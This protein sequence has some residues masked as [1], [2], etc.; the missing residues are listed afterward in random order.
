MERAHLSR[1]DMGH[2]GEVDCWCEPTPRVYKYPDHRKIMVVIHYD[3]D[4]AM[5]RE[6]I[7]NLRE[8]HRDS[9]TKLLDQVDTVV[10]PPTFFGLMPIDSARKSEGK[11]D[12]Q[13][14][15]LFAEFKR[16]NFDQERE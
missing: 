8:I 5:S 10:K 3:L 4:P 1:S 16:K 13:I 14:Q 9:I 11:I 7:L 15:R 2:L 6:S 12:P